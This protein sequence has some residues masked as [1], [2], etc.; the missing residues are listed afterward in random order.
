MGDSVLVA[1]GYRPP[2][3]IRCVRAHRTIVDAG[4]SEKKGNDDGVDSKETGLQDPV[5]CF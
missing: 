4:T 2:P 3:A 5:S 1:T